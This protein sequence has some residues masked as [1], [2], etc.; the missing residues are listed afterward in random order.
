MDRHCEA[1]VV[2]GITQQLAALKQFPEIIGLP[3]VPIW[4]LTALEIASA[5][6]YPS[7]SSNEC[8]SQ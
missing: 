2:F 3:F 1:P 8:A 7:D 6:K 4:W 5:R